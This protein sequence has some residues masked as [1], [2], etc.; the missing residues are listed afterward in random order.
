MRIQIFSDLHVGVGSLKQITVAKDVDLAVVAGDVAEGAQNAFATLRGFVPEA[1]PIV[2]T[3]GNHEYYR[4]FLGEELALARALAP[5][6]NIHLLENDCV[7]VGGGTVRVAG[8]S[9]W[10]D[11]RLFGDSNAPA[12]MHAARVGM[13]DHRL[14]GWKRKPWERF[15]PQEAALLHA[16]S[17]AFFVETFATPFDGLATVAVSHHAPHVGSVAAR[18]E[19]DILSAA[20]ASTFLEELDS[21]RQVVDSQ[22]PATTL[23][24]PDIWVHGH[25]HDGVDYRVGSTRVIA[26]PHGYGRENA[27]FDP[28]LVIEVGT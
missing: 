20:F 25:V 24:P 17:R 10:T 23:K 13:N 19:S 8:A 27:A 14:I 16:A 11:Y 9:L 1:V 18:F 12:A 7:V 3:M 2:F 4:R 5:D 22:Q 15:R 26:N 21:K 28:A 6:F